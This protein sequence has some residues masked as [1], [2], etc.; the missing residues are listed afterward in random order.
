MS[1]GTALGSVLSVIVLF[2]LGVIYALTRPGPV[3]DL[4]LRNRPRLWFPQRTRPRLIF[5]SDAQPNC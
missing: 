4:A 3:W 5:P 1:K 2:I